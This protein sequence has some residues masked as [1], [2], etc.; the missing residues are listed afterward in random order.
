MHF[1]YGQDADYGARRIFKAFDLKIPDSCKSPALH[2][3]TYDTTG[4]GVATTLM[5]ANAGVDI[6]DMAFNSMSGLTS[7]PA[8]NS[9]VAALENTERN[10]GIDLSGI[11][12]VSDYWNSV[13]PVYAQ[14]ES[15]LKS[16]S[17]EIYNY[18]IP[19]GQYSNL[20]PQVE[21][22]G[23]GHR[24][25]DVK[26][27]Y[28]K[29]NDMLGDIVKV[30]PS[31]KTVGDLA[32]FMVKNDLKPDN[33]YEKA[34][35]MAFPDSVVSYFKGM[36]GQPEWGFP[37]KL[38]KLVLKD[39]EPITGRPGELLP[40]EDFDK[41]E[42]HLS[43]KY[44]YNPSKKDLLSYAL[45]PDVF[46]D[47]LNFVMEYGD[48]S[49]MGS[50]VFF[51]GLAEGET[52]EIEVAEGRILIVQLI[53]IGKLDAEGNRVLEFEVNGNRREIRIKD[54]A[55]RIRGDKAEDKATKMADPS[56]K[57]DVGASIPGNIVKVLIKEGDKVTKGQN[58]VVIEA[59]K[60]ET[61][62][63]AAAPGTVES[64]YIKEGQRVKTGELLA[65]LKQDQMS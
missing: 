22:F 62:I 30:T 47:Y 25:H 16:G 19:G 59:M 45:Y 9:I 42:K 65:R 53:E 55:E 3:H 60:M 54:K 40:P 57:N 51:H 26:E 46:E 12:K 15:D 31:S 49:R 18:E 32:I 52:C 7:Q 17:A 44:R 34:G 4:N 8:L 23:L 58:L 64:V 36:M 35:N 20:K 37:E 43:K 24:F 33:I 5:A 28:K 50:D 61:V 10:T 38:Q 21:S 27:M 13:R 11:Q 41:V 2:L 14:F 48:F 6:V 56:N 39:I 29:V 63:I 1:T